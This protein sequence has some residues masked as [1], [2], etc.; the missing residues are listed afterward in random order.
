MFT[1]KFHENTKSVK[2]SP[3]MAELLGFPTTENGTL[4][5]KTSKAP[6]LPQLEGTAHSLYVYSSVV[7][8]QLV[9]HTVAPLLRVVCPTKHQMGE[10]VSEKYIRPYYM[11]VNTNYIDT[12]DIQI[13][14]TS[15]NLFPFLSGDPVIVNLHFQQRQQ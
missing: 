6:M 13:R 8:N 3:R 1:V 7:E 4:L 2:L 5:W 15:G 14:T 10:K 9:G 11:P 12:I